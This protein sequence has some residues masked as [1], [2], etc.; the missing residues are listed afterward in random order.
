M[1]GTQWVPR[2][3]S[4][5]K[6]EDIIRQGIGAHERAGGKSTARALLDL[7]E[8]GLLANQ[9][10]K[11]RTRSDKQGKAHIGILSLKRGERA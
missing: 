9:K 6:K 7:D 11:I 5:N 3:R 1:G 4:T 2:R 8:S 10:T